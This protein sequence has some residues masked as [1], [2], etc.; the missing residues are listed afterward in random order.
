MIRDPRLSRVTAG[1]RIYK[2][3]ENGRPA[4]LWYAIGKRIREDDLSALRA[5]GVKL[6]EVDRVARVKAEAA[7]PEDDDTAEDGTSD[8]G[9]TEGQGDG[10]EG[11]KTSETP[12]AAKP[13]PTPKPAAKPAAKPAESRAKKPPAKR[14]PA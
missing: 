11:E 4:Q 2:L 6:V 9:E 12:A 7:T 10:G 5:R 13:K 14:K 1:E 3:D 8:D